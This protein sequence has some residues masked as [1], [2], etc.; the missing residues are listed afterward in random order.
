MSSDFINSLING[1]KTIGFD[2]YVIGDKKYTFGVVNRDS[3][4]NI[5]NPH[6]QFAMNNTRT[7]T[8]DI[9]SEVDLLDEIIEI[10]KIPADHAAQ[11]MKVI[12]TFSTIKNLGLLSKEG[13]ED[14][15]KYFRSTDTFIK[16]RDAGYTEKEIFSGVDNGAIA[17][18]QT[19]V[20]YEMYE[21]MKGKK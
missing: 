20:A 16:L 9:K 21:L 2:E 1:S 8:F 4:I 14:F 15:R 11:I 12:K 5:L 7:Y 10:V 13:N 18:N 6:Y 17:L 3:K 19:A